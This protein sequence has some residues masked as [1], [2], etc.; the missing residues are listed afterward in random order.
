MSNGG[1]I[2]VLSE[3]M[4]GKL[5]G[6]VN[7]DHPHEKVANKQKNHGFTS[8][9][10]LDLILIGNLPGGIQDE[11]G[12]QKNLGQGEQGGQDHAQKEASFFVTHIFF[13]KLGQANN[14]GAYWVRQGTYLSHH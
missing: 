6:G 10:V 7:V 9:L 14:D 4:I 8:R 13:N 5:I 11:A 3:R 1:P 12:L 2:L